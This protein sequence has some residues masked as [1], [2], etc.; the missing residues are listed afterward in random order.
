[1]TTRHPM[2]ALGDFYVGNGQCLAC[3]VPHV[4]AP[5]LIAWADDRKSHCVW[6][7]QP[8][9]ESELDRAITVL[10]SQELDCHRYA[11][12]D[13]EILRRLPRNCCAYAQPWPTAPPGDRSY[14]QSPQFALL[15][16]HDNWLIRILKAIV[17]R[18][19]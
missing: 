12:S 6:L 1:M 15:D 5:D 7:K 8:E 2:S 11:G 13:S 16:E 4:V 19:L 17:R 3:G 10:E 14:N 18:R 9:S